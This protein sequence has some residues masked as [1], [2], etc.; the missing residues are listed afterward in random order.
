MKKLLDEISLHLPMTDPNLENSIIWQQELPC[1]HLFSL[2]SR[3]I[4][5]R[6]INT[7]KTLHINHSSRTCRPSFSHRRRHWGCNKGVERY[8]PARS[9]LQVICDDKRKDW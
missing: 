8:M 3:M 4:P 5:I 6:L 1:L 9:R 2:L 7:S